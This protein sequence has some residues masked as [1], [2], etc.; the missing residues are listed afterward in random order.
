M[1]LVTGSKILV[2][3]RRLFPEDPPRFFVGSVT[4]CEEGVV[5]A[6]GF[7]WTRDPSRGF[8][9][10]G[11]RRTKLIALASGTVIVYELPGE[12]DPEELDIEQPGGQAVVLTDGAKFSMDLA[13]RL[14]GGGV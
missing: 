7:S 12:I 11:D 14:P 2:C 4:A 8:Q 13:E 5:K 10:K 3:H 9:R 1:L 6:T